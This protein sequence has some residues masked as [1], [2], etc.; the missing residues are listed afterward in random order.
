MKKKLIIALSIILTVSMLTSSLCLSPAAAVGSPTANTSE[1]T[2]TRN[3]NNINANHYSRYTSPTRN[4]L[5]ATDTGYMRVYGSDDG[6]LFAEYYDAEFRFI[7]N[8]I[9]R[10]GL[11]LFGGFYEWGG[12]Y[13]VLTGQTNKEQNNTKEVFRVT[14]FSKDW[15]E[16]GR[17]SLKGANTT[18][19]FNAGRADFAGYNN[20]LIIRTSHEMY[21]SDGINH[22]ANVTI[23]LYIPTMST[24]G[25]YYDV[26]NI[27]AAGYI[28]HSFNQFVRID[29]NGAVVCLDH[30]DAGPRSAV[31]GV[32]NTRADVL[33]PFN[34]WEQTYNHADIVK[35]AGELGDNVTGAVIGGLECSDSNYLTVGASVEQNTSFASNKAF[36]AYISV[37]SKR[38]LN[39]TKVRY[40]TSF[41]EVDSRYASNP[42]LTKINNNTF[43]V[44][45]NELPVQKNI[46]EAIDYSSSEYEMKYVFVNGSGEM[47]SD[48]MSAPVG[49]MIFVSDCQPIVSGGKVMWF[50]T[51]GDTVSSIVAID[52]NGDIT[53]HE[54]IIPE[55]LI[56]YP[57]DLSK[58]HVAFRS[59]DR[60]PATVSIT[61]QNFNDYVVVYYHG[62][63]LT[64]G[65]EYNLR[66]IDNA[67][68][69]TVRNGYISTVK[70]RLADIAGYSYLPSAYTAYWEAVYNSSAYLMSAQRVNE[71]IKL[72]CVTTR[73]VGYYVFRLESGSF[74]YEQ[75]ATV[76]D[77]MTETYIDTTA[78]RTSSYTYKICEFTYDT[79]GDIVTSP[80]SSTRYVTGVSPEDTE[81]PTEPPTLPPT[82]PPTLSPTMP[83]TEPPTVPPTDP[84][85]EGSSDAPS[86]PPTGHGN[87]LILGDAD[88]N[89]EVTILDATSIQRH[90]ARLSELNPIGLMISDVDGSNELTII[91]AT[92]IQRFLAR[93]NSQYPIGRPFTTTTAL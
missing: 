53:V 37:T 15:V 65:K 34:N 25:S 68:T 27:N 32:Y 5:C 39:N 10:S 90:L 26:A 77:A 7:S 29:T 62:R 72:E 18:V 71:G 67:V 2:E 21:L 87:L 44:A 76:N 35:Y 56:S 36:N 43:L 48:I 88:L 63:A 4:Y 74:D 42:T 9:I 79:N 22:Q 13:F 78:H 20:T 91:D 19:P 11:P 86:E 41:T 40:L 85:T 59:F 3:A 58:A 31:L 51:D 54:H 38:N 64:P 84:P 61:P 82:E 83:P 49:R 33:T 66:D 73:G 93:L 1:Y 23:K 60:I 80:F 92:L 28:S 75:I 17:G 6:T 14:K 57:I 52:V 46:F 50:V 45:W 69:T 30:G 55:N 8:R 47:I 81:P 70:L 12:Y 24:E 16:Q 89:G